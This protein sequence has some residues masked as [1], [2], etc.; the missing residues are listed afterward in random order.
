MDRAREWTRALSTWCEAQPDLVPFT[1]ACL[2][3]RAEMMQL[4]GAWGEAIEEARRVTA[5]APRRIDPETTADSLYQQAEVHRLRGDLA[6]AERAYRDASEQGREAQPGLALLRMAQGRADDAL[7]ALRRM[8]RATT[9]PLQ[10]ARLLPA[11]VEIALGA[12]EVEE[13]RG[14]CRELASIAATFG[15]EVLG[16][17]A[18]Q[19]LGAVELADGHPEEALDPLRRAFRVWNDLG[20]PYLAARLR[21]LLARACHALEDRDTAELERQLARETFERLGAAPDL[22]ALDPPG[23]RESRTTRDRL[24]PRELEVLRLV[25]SGKTNKVIARELF[26]SEK[27]IDRHVSNI[28]V[29]AG[30]ASRAA[31]TAYAYQHRLV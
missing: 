26:L 31:A 16:A 14:A 19:A 25:A 17:M 28:F 20:A 2:V 21:V 5:L 3:H 18:A 13:A 22:A 15:T 29:K 11:Y 27:T 24:S 7:T 12:G 4:G 8:L 1:G 30:V 23:E 10:R 6:A 9:L